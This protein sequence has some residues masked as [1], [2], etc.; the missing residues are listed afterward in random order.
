MK[1]RAPADRRIVEAVV[2]AFRD[3]PERAHDRLAAFEQR[4]WARSYHWLD[5]SG[6]A[7]YLFDRLQ[8]F[9]IEDA[10]PAPTLERLRQNLADNRRRTTAM[11]WEFVV[12]NRAFREAGVRY[13]NLKGF[14]LAPESCP[15]PTLRCQV[16]FD[17]L[18]ER[19][20]LPLCRELLA[21]AGYQRTAATPTTWEFRAGNSELVRIEDHYKVRPQRAVELHFAANSGSASPHDDRLDRVIQQSWN[22]VSFPALSAGDQ[23]VEQAIHLL[24]HLR[25]AGT[26]LA[27]LLE[28]KHRVGFRFDDRP[29]W[30]EVQDRSASHRDASI[31]IGLATLVASQ[32]FGLEAPAQLDDWTLRRLPAPVRLW[33]DRY[34]RRAVLADSPGTKLY[35]LLQGELSRGDGSW[36]E[37]K[38]RRLLPLRLAPRILAAGQDDTVWKRLRRELVQA[39][40]ILFR[41]RFHLVEGLRYAIEARR[42]RRCLASLHQPAAHSAT[43]ESCLTKS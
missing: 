32:I 19:D 41:L 21:G 5:A 4:A 30:R 16:D 43:E 7:L 35:L 42:W 11:F 2:A 23:F 9:G 31:A 39:R 22:E 15:D 27:W 37:A 34:G 28:Y 36:P 17:F 14:T 25:D 38:R 3:P 1:W 10:L 33:A 40:F 8:T 12:L 6:M 13:A 18:V 29:F 26:R 20:Q 24:G